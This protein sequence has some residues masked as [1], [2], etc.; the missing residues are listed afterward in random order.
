MADKYW[1]GTGTWNTTNTA[2]WRTTSGG[3]TTTSVPTAADNVYFDANS[4]AGTCTIS[5]DVSCLT[6]STAGS[7]AINASTG[8]PTSHCW[9]YRN[10]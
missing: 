9:F 4:G 3:A 5:G 2:N 7:G 8:Y 6:F 10:W 1:V